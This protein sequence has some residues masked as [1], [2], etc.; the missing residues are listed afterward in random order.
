MDANDHLVNNCPS[1]RWVEAQ[2]VLSTS[3]KQAILLI[4]HP[5]V[6]AKIAQQG[7]QLL[8]CA[9]DQQELLWLSPTAIFDGN[10][11]IRGGI[12]VCLPWFG[13]NQHDPSLPKHGFARN[14]D[15]LL[16]AA[17]ETAESVEIEFS[18]RSKTHP[19][20]PYH[21]TA[22][23]R[24]RFHSQGIDAAFSI[25]NR[26]DAPLTF[27]YALHSYLAVADSLASS[28]AGLENT[29]F[30]D[31]TN[32]LLP[33][34]QATAIDFQQEVDRVYLNC[35]EQ[36]FLASE[37]NMMIRSTTMPSAI[38][39]N[40]GEAAT[41]IADIGIAYRGYVCVERGAVLAD[42]IHLKSQQSHAAKMQ[43]LLC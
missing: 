40:P 29:S 23:L 39:W 7:A 19:L 4:D 37:S 42:S 24:Y 31:N 27:S 41:S 3:S 34:T 32:S 21:F 38:V 6:K 15:W 8:S 14:Q 17:A 12:P 35:P 2:A 43:L 13:V 16:T 25:T 1:M 11:A 5:L 33:S 22:N 30:L 9:I 28:V 26:S 18:F 20:F 10:T 36:Q